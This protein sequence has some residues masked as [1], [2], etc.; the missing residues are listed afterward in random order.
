M[1]AVQSVLDALASLGLYSPFHLE[2]ASG[3]YM[4]SDDIISLLVMAIITISL[5]LLVRWVYLRLVRRA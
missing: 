5:I 3:C 2:F 1:S 4:S